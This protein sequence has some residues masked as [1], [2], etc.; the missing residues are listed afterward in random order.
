MHLYLLGTTSNLGGGG[1]GGGGGKGGGGL[2]WQICWQLSVTFS[3]TALEHD[4]WGSPWVICNK[5]KMS[6]LL[7]TCLKLKRANKHYKLFRFLSLRTDVR[8]RLVLLPVLPNY[9]F[10]V[11]TVY[12]CQTLLFALIREQKRAQTL[13]IWGLHTPHTHSS[14]D[15]ILHAMPLISLIIYIMLTIKR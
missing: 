4:F 11:F 13:L 6:Y 9:L 12:F 10:H 14:L 2:H 8:T 3:A 1:G 7:E 15:C 5:K